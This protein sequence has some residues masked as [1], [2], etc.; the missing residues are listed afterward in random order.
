MHW[1]SVLG[2]IASR[3]QEACAIDTEQLIHDTGRMPVWLGLP[4][5]L[6]GMVALWIAAHI[7][8]SH[9]FGFRLMPGTGESGSPVLG[10]LGGLG[11]GLFLVSVPFLRNRI[12]YDSD[13]QQVLVR[14]SGL[15]GLSHRRVSLASATAVEIVVGRVPTGR[16]WNIYIRHADGRGKW[17]TQLPDADEAERVGA[18]LSQA[19]G[20]PSLKA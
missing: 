10:F 20:L 19:T 12:F 8:S 6:I 14:H 3:H 7:A 9:L 15:L 18:A 17:L 13:R 5:F 11:L 16:H 1:L 2:R 4:A